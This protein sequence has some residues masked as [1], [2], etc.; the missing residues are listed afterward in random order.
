M[1]RFARK[2]VLIGERFGRLVTVAYAGKAKDSRHQFLCKCDC[3][4]E[5]IVLEKHLR[6][7]N[8]KSCGCFKKDAG[9]AANTTHGM[10]KTRIYGIWAGMKDRCTNPGVAK[11]KDYGAR[12]I[13]VCQE[14]QDSFEAFYEWAM[15]NGYKDHLTIERIDNDGNYC[16]ENCRWA[17]KKEQANNKRS[18]V[19]ITFN[20]ET[21][22]LKQWSEIVGVNYYTMWNRYKAG[23]PP[24]EILRKPKE[25]M[26]TDALD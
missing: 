11:F 25:R 22:T 9:I 10:R 8:T 17:T 4:N 6:N 2:P 20:G 24:A 15:A 5:T 18:S 14:W 13:T 19:F 3:G 12:G 26:M 1:A 23:Q 16:P 7:G 21:H